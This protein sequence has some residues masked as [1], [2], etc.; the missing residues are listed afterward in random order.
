MRRTA[1]LLLLLCCATLGAQYQLAVS[2]RNF[3][4]HT[5]DGNYAVSRS[6]LAQLDTR[7]DALHMSLGVYLDAAAPV[8]M[9]PDSVAY[10]SLTGGQSAIVEFSDAFYSSADQRIYIRG[11]APL[12]TSYGG[13]I[14]HE[15][16]HWYLDQLLTGAPLWLHEGLATLHGNQLGLDRYYLYV[17][18]RFWGRNL[19][20]F[21][22]AYTYP[23]RRQDWELYYL[24]SFFAVKYMRDQEPAAWRAF[25]AQ[26]D[27][28]Q[29]RGVKTRFGPA[30]RTAYGMDL[31]AF[32]QSFADHSRRQA[33]IYLLT[34]FGSLLFTALPLL[35]IWAVLRHRRRLRALPDLP[36][37]EET[38]SEDADEPPPA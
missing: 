1:M 8:Y 37:P 12:G 17:R 21:S 28:N 7:V 16:T 4:I 23:E 32:H 5:P 30:F 22:L 36:L 6:F 2:T 11:G 13:I 31:Y 29:R 9:V 38:T 26:V 3:S 20:L 14:L 25:W 19:D 24:A 33:W 18:E 15:Y 34:G 10:E 35:L 27:A